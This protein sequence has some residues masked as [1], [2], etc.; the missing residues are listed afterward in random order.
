[1]R[2][3]ILYIVFVISIFFFNVRV[4]RA[5]IVP[6]PKPDISVS[7]KFNAVDGSNALKIAEDPT[8][9]K[10]IIKK[11]ENGAKYGMSQKGYTPNPVIEGV[12]LAYSGYEALYA[13]YGSDPD[14]QY[15]IRPYQDMDTDIWG[16]EYVGVNVVIGTFMYGEERL[17][18]VI[19]AKTGEILN[20][21][22]SFREGFEDSVDECISKIK[23]N[24]YCPIE[25]SFEC[26]QY[27]LTN[28]SKVVAYDYVVDPDD[29]DVYVAHLTW[30]D[31]IIDV[32]PSE[33]FCCF[34]KDGPSKYDMMS[35]TM[36]LVTK[37]KLPVVGE[38]VPYLWRDVIISDKI[39]EFTMYNHLSP[40]AT[41]SKTGFIYKGQHGG[42]HF[43]H[44][45]VGLQYNVT[46]LNYD[47]YYPYL[48]LRKTID[49]FISFYED[50]AGELSVGGILFTPVQPSTQAF[51][52]PGNVYNSDKMTEYTEK[53]DKKIEECPII[54]PQSEPYPGS[55]P[56]PGVEAE[57]GIAT[58][59][60]PVIIPDPA[61]GGL[62]DIYPSIDDVIDTGPV[63][64]PSSGEEIGSNELSP[65]QFDLSKKFPFCVPFDL[66]KSI[67]ILKKDPVAP[68]IK[69][70]LKADII[71]FEY[72]FNIDLKDF[73]PVA[74]I[75]RILSTLAFIMALIMATRNLIRG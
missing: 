9:Q 49:E 35:R 1:M 63:I 39:G 18:A 7:P 23:D 33:H 54:S 47:Y 65:Y 27:G 72:T 62:I 14:Y 31:D 66:I 20:S 37:E 75:S 4:V 13:L 56:A 26:E 52:Q 6:F 25:P 40:P 45:N 5:E 12:S 61:T 48:T 19:D 34:L 57:P 24:F 58:R 41:A 42:F 38:S 59:A 36:M 8:F 15:Y 70:T 53:Q 73:E 22:I 55:T 68:S 69:W 10:A 21:V 43:Y 3:I 16:N 64:D 32:V 17:D 50:N 71:N 2:K 51:P 60:L 30:F 44:L 29:K 46:W 74:K 28:L 67:K 11:F